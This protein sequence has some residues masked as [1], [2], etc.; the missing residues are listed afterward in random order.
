MS[1]FARA[2]SG[3]SSAAKPSAD[4]SAPSSFWSGQDA[5]SSSSRRT[6][7]GGLDSSLS[8]SRSAAASSAAP[9]WTRRPA[10][11][12]KRTYGSRSRSNSINA[13][14][15][16][17]V[18]SSMYEDEDDSPSET[19]SVLP[20]PQLKAT[21]ESI[22]KA[23]G[24]SQQRVTAT[25][26]SRS[27]RRTRAAKQVT[28]S[29]LPPLSAQQ[30]GATSTCASRAVA[31]KRAPLRT[32]TNSSDQSQSDAQSLAASTDTDWFDEWMQPSQ[33]SQPPQPDAA[34]RAISAPITSARI[35]PKAQRRSSSESSIHPTATV[36]PVTI[37]GGLVFGD[38]DALVVGEKR[39]RNSANICGT[40][41]DERR[42]AKYRL[43]HIASPILPTTTSSSVL[44]QG[45]NASS[46]S[47]SAKTRQ[48]ARAVTAPSRT[49]QPRV[50]QHY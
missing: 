41:G 9:Q 42:K 13:G 39:P 49:A 30:R 24:K 5:G 27:P 19:T 43:T 20:S 34:E 36:Q 7:G 33:P 40:P 38:T 18:L 6:Y 29:A 10:S 46:A 44:S 45:S 16:P 48:T 31:K 15:E 12:V 17:V 2:P 23:G 47:S 50:S 26:A 1:W 3:T 14:Q 25:R 35:K 4:E 11:S 32:L 28:S 37:L 21:T 8:S 22:F